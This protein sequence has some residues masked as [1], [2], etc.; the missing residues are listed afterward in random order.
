MDDV[1]RKF[2]QQNYNLVASDMIPFN[3]SLQDVQ[4]RECKKLNYPRK[5]PKTSIIIIFYNEGWSSLL[6]FLYHYYCPDYAF[7][8]MF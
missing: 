3:R 1:N 4:Y 6:R 7:S 8:I 2:S 5:L